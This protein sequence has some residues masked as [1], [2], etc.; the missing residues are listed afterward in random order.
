MDSPSHSEDGTFVDE[1]SPRDSNN[2]LMEDFWVDDNSIKGVPKPIPL[3]YTPAYSRAYKCV[4]AARI[5]ILVLNLF[6]VSIPIFS[7]LDTAMPLL[8]IASATMFSTF[9]PLVL[10][11]VLDSS[12]QKGIDKEIGTDRTGSRRTA[13]LVEDPVTGQERWMLEP[14]PKMGG[15]EKWLLKRS[16]VARID[17]YCVAMFVAGI[18]LSLVYGNHAS[19]ATWGLVFVKLVTL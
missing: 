3:L 9:M 12:S 2:P 17:A 16:S 8:P 4:C 14:K 19:L 5:L 7:G 13:I 6:Q 1:M 18:V 11:A 10:V 15:L